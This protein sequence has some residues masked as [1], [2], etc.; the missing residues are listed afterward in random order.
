MD[1]KTAAA[2]VEEN[3]KTVFAYALH[4]VDTP[5]DAEDLA[6]DILVSFLAHAESIRDDRAI[7]GY[8]WTVA[9]HAVDR[10]RKHKARARLHLTDSEQ[11]P[12]TPDPDSDFAA[13]LAWAEEQAE[14]LRSLRKALAHLAKEYRTCTV[15]YYFDGL[16]CRDIAAR[17][18]LSTEMVKYYLYK[19]R[20]ILKEGLMVPMEYGEKSYRPATFHFCTIF[21]GAYNREYRNLFSRKLPGN[22]LYCAYYTP[23][24]VGELS[25]ELGVASVYLEDEIELLKKYNLLTE[26]R[27]KVQTRLVIYTEAYETEF[28]QAVENKLTGV[29]MEILTAAKGKMGEVR[30]LGFPGCGRDD[31]RL[32]WALYFELIRLGYGGMPE[33]SLKPEIY[34]G[35]R[36]IN[37][38][39]DYEACEGA[40][41][42]RAFAGYYGLGENTAAS[43]ADFGILP[44]T[45][46]F[47]GPGH[48][49]KT[50]ARLTESKAGGSDAPFVYL[51]QAQVRRIFAE[52]LAPEVT[53]L[54]RFYQEL[55]AL[56][57]ETLRQH[58]PKSVW[59]ELDMVVVGT[60][61]HR[62]VGLLGKLAVDTGV[63]TVPA[64]AEVPTAVFL[65]ETPTA[66]EGCK[67]RM[68]D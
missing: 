1:R 7:F 57:V 48:W 67:G 36:G 66:S 15:A 65:Y 26:E 17:E 23:M 44:E 25:V 60:L 27:G 8:L 13:T 19:T 34:S 31:N 29:L 9:A 40:Y 32:L 68:S 6:Q 53:A 59:E 54:T 28:R 33:V 52:I 39:T 21:D 18:G 38:A 42:A 64:S 62:T 56:S 10:Y 61:F 55:A 14:A 4:R 45:Q 16:S 35:A 63:L 22:I 50:Q 24:T 43:F 30:A 5:S 46:Y 2:I 49:E 47:D 11:V 58:A 12:D 37:Y 20:R 41:G 51:T 3:M